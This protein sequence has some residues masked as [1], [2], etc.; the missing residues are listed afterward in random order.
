M[1][2][3]ELL[4]AMLLMSIILAPLIGGFVSMMSA[5]AR[6]ANIV[7]AQ[8]QARLA[9]QRMRKD[10]HCAH[11]VA[12]PQANGS[13]GYTLILSETNTTGVAEC[14][15]IVAQ[16][17]SSVQWCT[18]PV[19][20]YTNRYRLY[21]EDDPSTSCDGTE[22]SFQVD[23]MTQPDIWTIPSCASGDYPTVGV[24]FSVDLD[25]GTTDEGAYN[26]DDAIA[27]RNATTC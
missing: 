24:D 19:T 23:Y 15:G 26:L 16:N 4:V 22:S 3:V 18:V 8:E 12:V 14:P 5:Q 10:I 7:T 2:L 27:L 9:L 20:G 17:S 13:G 1:T 11:S 21:R 6:Q 25:P